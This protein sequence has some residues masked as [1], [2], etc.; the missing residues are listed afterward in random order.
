VHDTSTIQIYDVC[1]YNLDGWRT[2]LRHGSTLSTHE[3]SLKCAF[4]G[5]NQY[6]YFLEAK[7]RCKE[8][9]CCVLAYWWTGYNKLLPAATFEI[10]KISISSLPFARV[11]ETEMLL[12]SVNFNSLC[13]TLVLTQHILFLATFFSRPV[14][15]GVFSVQNRWQQFIFLFHLYR[16]LVWCIYEGWKRGV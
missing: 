14:T 16:S 4:V 9:V 1:I 15:S 6:Y 13:Q 2:L 8:D 11:V 7:L 3:Q 12:A 5:L 10:C